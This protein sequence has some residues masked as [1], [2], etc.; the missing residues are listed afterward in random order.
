MSG[1]LLLVAARFYISLG[2]QIHPDE[3]YYWVW[4]RYLDWAYY[5]QGPGVAWYIAMFTHLF[6]ESWWVLK[7]AALVALAVVM[8]LLW[9]AGRLLGLGWH[10]ST[11]V[12]VLFY[13]TPG[14][15]LGSDLIMHDTPFLMAWML[16]T[17]SMLHY[18]R[19]RR[20]V[21]LYVMFVAIG[22]GALSKHSMAI[23]VM[24]WL[25]WLVFQKHEYYLW[26]SPH[27]WVGALIVLVLLT[28]IWI[29]N[30]DHNWD[31]IDAIRYLRSAGGGQRQSSTGS[32]IFG[33]L[34]LF[35]PLWFLAFALLWFYLLY[36]FFRELQWPPLRRL[37]REHNLRTFLRLFSIEVR[38]QL[39]NWWMVSRR[40]GQ[41]VN[42][43]IAEQEL[44]RRSALWFIFWQASFV[45]LFFVVMSRT[46]V[47]QAN[48]LIPGWPAILLLMGA[49]LPFHKGALHLVRSVWQKGYGALILLGSL[50]AIGISL[51]A[52]YGYQID[53]QLGLRLPDQAFLQFRTAGYREMI[54][55]LE[56]VRR[57]KYP[58]AI[59]IA[60]RYQD[61]AIAEWYLRDTRPGRVAS[62]N[63]SQ[64][65]QYSYWPSLEKGQDYLIFASSENGLT[66]VDPFL[67]IWLD[68]MFESVTTADEQTVTHQG[69]L[70]KK[71]RYWYA[72]NFRMAWYEVLQIYL[73][74]LAIL[75]LM[76]SMR[77]YNKHL[78]AANAAASGDNLM[79]RMLRLQKC[80]EPDYLEMLGNWLLNKQSAPRCEA[81]KLL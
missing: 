58:N 59:L 13:L 55:Q 19:H 9:S 16:A 57:Q 33:Q 15:F 63:I 62:M 80:Y 29:W 68:Y 76:P 74:R 77:G 1:I 30:L 26:R 47:V 64:K 41:L 6:Q 23:F 37:W 65:N 54:A 44:N 38:Q 18:L 28:P 43:S 34:F 56:Q 48:W 21:Y 4:S 79:T 25:L 22:L 35:S 53:Q 17:W 46:S 5:D 42:I 40:D 24:A 61:A 11:I 39:T 72:R 51:F 27:V 71:Y 69:V 20:A 3:A 12:V 70:V 32:L 78:K 14:V 8:A 49:Y 45:I 31:Q 75:D 10:R 81:H 7:L 2:E 60:N 36:R 50:P 52:L 73:D 66:P 67:F